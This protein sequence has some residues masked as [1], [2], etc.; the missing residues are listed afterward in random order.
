MF[1]IEKVF[2]PKDIAIE[3]RDLGFDEFCL[4]Y[5]EHNKTAPRFGLESRDI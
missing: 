2:V 3:L 5:Y 1:D 4:F